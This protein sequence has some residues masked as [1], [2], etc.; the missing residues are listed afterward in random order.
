MIRLSAPAM[1]LLGLI[2][3][4]VLLVLYGPLLVAIFF[5]FFKYENNAVQWDS[6]SFD[7]YRSLVHDEGIIDAVLNTLLV[8]GIAVSLALILGTA[9][10][11]YYNGSRSRFRELLQLVIFLPF[12]MPPIITGLS[13]LVFF[14]ETDIPRSLITVVIGHTVFV[15]ALV[16]RIILTRLQ[17]VR[18]SL[19]EAS[20]DLGASRWQTFRYVLAPSLMSAIGS[21][22]ILA[23]ALSFDETLIT[24]LVTGTQSTLPMRL[25]AMMRMGFTPDINALVTIVLAASTGFALLAIR[26]VGVPTQK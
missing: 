15:L 24:L 22:A 2:A 19:V 4:F 8:G 25:W 18:A 20:L 14:R 1:A 17:T 10:A 11:F 3:A 21:A 13:L 9:L 26:F 12:L 6:F 7:A 23:F 5:S 16:Y